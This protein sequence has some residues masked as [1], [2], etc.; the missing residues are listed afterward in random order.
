MSHVSTRARVV[1]AAAIGVIGL[2]IAWLILSGTLT[3]SGG[4]QIIDSVRRGG[5]TP[6]AGYRLLWSDEFNGPAGAAPDPTKWAY[7]T[8]GS[9]FGN[10]ELQYYTARPINGSLDGN[11]HLAITARREVYTGPDGVTRYYTSALLQTAGLFSTTYG[12]IQARIQ[13]PA[14]AGL[15]PAFWAIGANF[16]RVPWPTSGEMDLMENIGSNP[17]KFYGVLH[18]PQTGEKY[19]YNLIASARSASSLAAG[20]HVFGIHWSPG[21]IVFLMDGVPYATRTP[22][23]LPP[24][25]KWVFD[26]PFYFVLDL[27]VGGG[28]PGPPG[29]TTRFPA[30]MLVDWV[31]VYAN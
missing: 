3:S 28:F 17:F 12:W 2:A 10:G 30:T 19:G 26:H 21:K 11:G 23:S 29:P 1:V 16:P 27:A 14:G 24:G 5:L 22:A 8:G 15:W 4:L 31:R 20:F 6:P 25:G 13:L 7:E 18:G 9:G